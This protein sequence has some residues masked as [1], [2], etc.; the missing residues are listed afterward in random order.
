M[1]FL[2][3]CMSTESSEDIHTLEVRINKLILFFKNKKGYAPN[4]LRLTEVI[5]NDIHKSL[6]LSK[7]APVSSLLYGKYKDLK[8]VSINSE[9]L[10][11]LY[12]G[13]NVL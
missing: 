2:D 3:D 6:K 13:H 8:I 11:V 9:Y 7:Y 10:C 5:A 12:E 4:A 1:K